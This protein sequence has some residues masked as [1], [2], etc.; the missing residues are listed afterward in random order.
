MRRVRSGAGSGTLKLLEYD[1]AV[2]PER[3]SLL[4]GYEDVLE[5]PVG[6]LESVSFIFFIWMLNVD[7]IYLSLEGIMVSRL[8]LKIKEEIINN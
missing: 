5:R 6:I 4:G 2:S 7:L 3:T 1:L 8:C